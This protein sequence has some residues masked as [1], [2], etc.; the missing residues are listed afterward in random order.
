MKTQGDD[1]IQLCNVGDKL[2]RISSKYGHRD[3]LYIELITITLAKFTGDPVFGH[4]YYHD[5]KHRS[6]FNRNIR[7]SCYK[8]KEE[9][10]KELLKR[11][12]IMRKREALKEYERKLN[13]E[14]NINDHYIVK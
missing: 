10:E 6:Y 1:I 12:A 11:E 5:N 3:E 8:T 2:Y 7:K 9:A 4:W 13:K 14:L